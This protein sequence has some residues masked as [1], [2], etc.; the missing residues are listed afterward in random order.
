MTP[1]IELN[2]VERMVVAVGVGVALLL[3]GL[4]ASGSLSANY[5]FFLLGL[6]GMYVLLAIGLN[7]QWGYAGLIN[8]SVA[9]FF[10]IGAYSVALVTSPRSPL[11]FEAHPIFGLLLAI[12]L[13]VIVALLIGVPTLRLRADYLAIATLGLA[14]VIRLIVL[15]EQWLTRGSAGLPGIPRITGWMPLEWLPFDSAN[16]RNFLIAVAL[17]A[18]V[19]LFVRRIHRSPWGRVLRTIRADEDLARAL[20]KDTYRFKMQAFV[21]GS[22]VMALAGVFY[23]HLNLFLGPG[24]LDPILTFYVWIAVIV[25]GSGSDRGAIIGGMV[26]VAILEGTRLLVGVTPIDA[27]VGPLRLLLVGLLI[28]LVVRY[29]S[30]GILPPQRELIWPGADDGS[31]GVRPDGGESRE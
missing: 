11:G 18:L 3:A 8:F 22:V 27:D 25:G 20:G 12:V 9:A 1:S 24:D 26:V 23:A 19:F 14:E 17:I 7:I 29:R 31:T 10:G 28:V 21:L 6:G 2:R 5:L 4:V 15:N 13:S 16:F 30:Q